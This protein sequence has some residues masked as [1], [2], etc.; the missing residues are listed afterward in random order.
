[1]TEENIKYL[2]WERMPHN[3]T[4][5]SVDLISSICR[6]IM[7]IKEQEDKPKKQKG[8][9]SRLKNYFKRG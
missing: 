2:V 7:E 5:A 4:E 8:F 1:M 6:Q 3:T 9:F